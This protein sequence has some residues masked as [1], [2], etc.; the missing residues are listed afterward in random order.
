MSRTFIL[1][2]P[3]HAKAMVAYVKEHAGPQAAAKRPLVVTVTEYKAKRSSEANARYWALLGEIAEQVEVN[4][5]WFSRDVWHEWA[6]EQYA[7]KVEGPSGLLTVSTTQMNVEQF[8]QYM[9]QIESYAAQ[10]L[11]VEFAAV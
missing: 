6:K 5:K 1:R 10:E 7:P 2:D 3:E 9:T 4:G 8:T 11:G